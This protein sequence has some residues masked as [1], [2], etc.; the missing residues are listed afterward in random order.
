M[1]AFDGLREDWEAT[2]PRPWLLSV[3]LMVKITLGIAYGT[4]FAIWL[5]VMLP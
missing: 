5:M 2:P 3:R 4:A 1:S